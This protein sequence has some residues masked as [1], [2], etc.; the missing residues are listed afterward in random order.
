LAV[1]C[2][3]DGYIKPG[4]W[5]SLIDY[6]A[7]RSQVPV[8]ARPGLKRGSV[9]FMRLTAKKTGRGRQPYEEFDISRFAGEL[10]DD[11]D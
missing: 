11:A 6:A 10:I 8:L 7:E 1:Q 4:E 2:K 9:Q 3:H 5:N